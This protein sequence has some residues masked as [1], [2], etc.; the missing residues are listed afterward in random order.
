M[1][2]GERTF[3]LLGLAARGKDVLLQPHNRFLP[4]FDDTHELSI[5]Q[6]SHHLQQV[7]RSGGGGETAGGEA[8]FNLN[9]T[10]PSP[11]ADENTE[12]TPPVPTPSPTPTTTTPQN[13]DLPH[14]GPADTL[15]IF[16]ITVVTGAGLYELRLR[17]KFKTPA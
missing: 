17:R 5:A 4:L 2:E 9:E 8:P 3:E 6:C 13:A 15:A 1:E 14:T 7:D 11:T 16:I 12:Q 10:S